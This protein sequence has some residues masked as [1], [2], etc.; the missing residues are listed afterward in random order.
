[1]KSTYSF[2]PIKIEKF[3]KSVVENNKDVNKENLIRDIK[4]SIKD[5]KN[6]A[7]CS[8]G[9]P[10]WVAGSAFLGNACFTCI[11]G[12]TDA[13]EDYEIDEVIKLLNSKRQ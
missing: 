9:N 2:I 10:I 3:A 8:C 6:G 5:V 13:S 4:S 7:K 12:E 1:M 11:T